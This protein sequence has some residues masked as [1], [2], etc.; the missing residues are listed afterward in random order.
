MAA[1]KISAERLTEFSGQMLQAAGVPREEAVIISR[2]LVSSDLRG[3]ESHGVLRL[4]SYV[5]K[6]VKKEA[7]PKARF[8]IIKE[9]ATLV[10]ADGNWGFGQVQMYRLMEKAM[11]KAC[12]HGMAVGTLF[13]VTHIGRL[14]EYAELAA[15]SS[16]ASLIMANTHSSRRVAPPG[17][18]TPRIGTNPIAFSAPYDD[19]PLVLDFCTA[20]TAEGK[21]R[22][23]R[24]AGTP[25]PDGWLQDNK[26]K[27]T[28]DPNALYT[29][30]PGAILPMGGIQTYKGF[31]LALMAEIFAGALSGGMCI[32][33]KSRGPLGNCVFMMLLSPRFFGGMQR[34]QKEV[35][36]LVEYIRACPTVEGADEIL[37]PGDPERRALEKRLSEGIPIEEN[38]WAALAELAQSLGVPPPAV[39]GWENLPSPH[40]KRK[41]MEAEEENN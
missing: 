39:A 18:K 24:F 15:E 1:I 27:P 2:S 38:N 3:H 22:Q 34:F 33:E 14:G 8:S 19:C 23:R 25:C 36:E 40:W 41:V 30:P 6:I 21:I 5:D 35:A 29:I 17:G 9:R 28:N 37:L 16:L 32:C 26:G 20:A 10:M 13:N 4:P 11:E 7:V 31:G 12:C